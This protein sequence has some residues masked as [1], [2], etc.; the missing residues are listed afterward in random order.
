VRKASS[1]PKTLIHRQAAAFRRAALVLGHN[2]RLLRQAQGWTVEQASEH[3]GIEPAHIR[4]IESGRTNPSLAVL[5]SIA[6]ALGVAL[7]D[8]VAGRARAR[9]RAK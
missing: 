9:S 7:S 5:V 4:R 3:F 6:G 2:V 1:I 8:L